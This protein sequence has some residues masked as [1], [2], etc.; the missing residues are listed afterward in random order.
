MAL[1]CYPVDE[2]IAESCTKFEEQMKEC[3]HKVVRRDDPSAEEAA[4]FFKELGDETV[5]LFISSHGNSFGGKH[6]LDSLKGDLSRRE[7]GKADDWRIGHGKIG[8]TVPIEVFEEEGA[9]FFATEPILKA[10][11]A[12][13]KVLSA[14]FSGRAC[15]QTKLSPLVG[16][17]IASCGCNETCQH[18]PIKG[19]LVQEP[20]LYWA[21]QLYCDPKLL[22]EVDGGDGSKKDGVLS[23]TEIGR[24]IA[25]KMGGKKTI[26][27]VFYP[28]PPN[29]NEALLGLVASFAHYFPGAPTLRTEGSVKA[30]E[31]RRKALAVKNKGLKFHLRKAGYQFR[32]RFPSGFSMVLPGAY[33]DGGMA[34][35]AAIKIG[36]KL[37]KNG[38]IKDAKG[39]KLT[40]IG[41]VMALEQEDPGQ[42][43]RIGSFGTPQTPRIEGS[44][45]PKK[46]H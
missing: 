3:G 31:S 44:I 41:P 21:A 43:C 4:T 19:G 9:R 11:G 14:C 22:S 2:M 35:R 5:P 12:R 30:M 33:R 26:A 28:Q 1:F 25:T 37:Q 17:L 16:G 36:E 42:P 13:T 8:P 7:L 39:L 34:E 27:E 40:E 32:A 29:T 15:E 24:F 38:D 10:A 46:S 23:P 20:V 18:M 45:Q 6:Y